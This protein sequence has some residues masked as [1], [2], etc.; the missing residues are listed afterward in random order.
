M[1]PLVSALPPGKF[2]AA[3]AHAPVLRTHNNIR[4]GAVTK[5]EVR[6]SCDQCSRS[7]RKCDGEN[8]CLSCRRLNRCCNYSFKLKPGPQ[9]TKNKTTTCIDPYALLGSVG[10]GSAFKTAGA[11][12]SSL[13]SVDGQSQYLSGKRSR[14]ADIYG[15]NEVSP[16]LFFFLYS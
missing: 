7:K 4:A 5:D 15:G 13:V 10:A 14:L 2:C 6:K 12:P 1:N 16:F 3:P 11:F 9:T 8:P